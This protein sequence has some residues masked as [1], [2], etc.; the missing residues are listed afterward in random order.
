[1]CVA[2]ERTN[3]LFPFPSGLYMNPPK[4]RVDPPNLKLR[5]DPPTRNR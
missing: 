2:R 5:V 4:L 3:Y 1:M